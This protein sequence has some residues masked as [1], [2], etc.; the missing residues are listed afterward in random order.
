MPGPAS[1]SGPAEPGTE[2]VVRRLSA[3]DLSILSLETETVAGHTCKVIM[4]GGEIDLD[5]LR[6]SI[7]ARLH[8]APELCMRLSEIDGVPCWVQEDEVDIAAHIG[9][10]DQPD[11]RT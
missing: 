9:L 6:S 11:A 8:R 1:S 4:L 10:C 2:R 3:E 7:S 5:L